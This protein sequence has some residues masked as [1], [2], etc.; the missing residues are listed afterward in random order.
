M[1]SVSLQDPRP[2]ISC[3]LS[4][5]NYVARL[6][7]KDLG[8]AQE[9]LRPVEGST[10]DTLLHLPYLSPKPTEVKRPLHLKQ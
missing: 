8:T 4:Y 6:D 3:W 5:I 7:G 1:R 2:F 10:I 9:T